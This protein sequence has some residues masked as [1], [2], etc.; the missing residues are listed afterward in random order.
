METRAARG[1][2]EPDFLKSLRPPYRSY[3]TGGGGPGP[4]RYQLASNGVIAM[5]IF[6]IAEAM[7]FAGLISAFTIGK[8][9]AIGGWPPPGQPRLPVQET[10]FNTAALLL[11]GL[12]MVL[13]HRGFASRPGAARRPLLLSILLGSFFVL[14]QGVEWVALIREGLTLTTSTH[15]AFFY[16]IVGAHALHA[17]AAIAALIYIYT[18]LIGGRSTPS[19]FKT[20]GLFW[21]FVVGLWPILYWRVY[22]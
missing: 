13:A 21:Y 6:I 8:T 5:V 14:F 15:G 9:T 16:L 11:S 19:E 1:E 22:L 17:V 18:R 10:A 3:P 20:A 2:G 12:F 7:F 4:R